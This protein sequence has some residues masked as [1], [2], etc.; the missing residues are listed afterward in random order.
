MIKLKEDQ[1]KDL[2]SLYDEHYVN[3]DY[4]SYELAKASYLKGAQSRQ[5][6][7]DALREMVKKLIDNTIL[8]IDDE[9]ED[10]ANN[11]L[12]GNKDEN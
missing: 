4:K 6:E 11:L 9:L 5:A 8:S 1:Y 2:N 12:K 3:H 10:Q 7:I